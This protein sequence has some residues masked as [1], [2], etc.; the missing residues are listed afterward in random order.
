MPLHALDHFLVEGLVAALQEF[1][2]LAVQGDAFLLLHLPILE[3]VCFL[4]S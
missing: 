1:A 4:E 3:S 2:A